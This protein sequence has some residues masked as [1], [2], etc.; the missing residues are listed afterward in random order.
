M[1][2]VDEARKFAVAEIDEHGL[3]NIVHFEISEKKALELAEKLNADKTIVHVGVCLMDLKLGQSLK[4]N[5]ISEHVKMSVEST[6]EFLNRFDI[7][8]ASK[9]KIINCV[10]AHHG[11]PYKCT[12]A[13]ICANADCYRFIHPKGFFVYLTVLGRRFKDFLDALNA[14]E[15]KMDEKHGILS[16]DVCKNELEKYYQAL[17]GFIKDSKT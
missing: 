1:E 6:K 12:E 13:E 9:E 14:A 7:D 4:E 2:I 10:E 8:N 16:L 15:K 3:P 17:K 5:R 11:G